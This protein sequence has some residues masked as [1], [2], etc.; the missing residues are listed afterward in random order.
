MFLFICRDRELQITDIEEERHRLREKEHGKN[1]LLEAYLNGLHEADDKEIT[2]GNSDSGVHTEETTTSPEIGATSSG[3]MDENSD[4]YPTTSRKKSRSKREAEL[5]IEHE[6]IRDSI[7]NK[8]KDPEIVPSATNNDDELSTQIELLERLVVLNKHLQK[9]EELLVRLGAKIKRY[10]ADASGLTEQQVKEAIEKVDTQLNQGTSELQH[11]ECQIKY[12]DEMLQDKSNALKNLYDE[13]E[14]AEIEHGRLSQE[15][16][17]QEAVSRD[18]AVIP[19]ANVNQCR[20]YLADNVYNVSKSILKTKSCYDTLQNREIS[21]YI[22]HT[23]EHMLLNP[24]ISVG[25]SYYHNTNPGTSSALPISI[26]HI[27][28][29]QPPLQFS[30]QQTQAQI[31]YSPDLTSRISNTKNANTITSVDLL[32]S[33][34]YL[35]K[36]NQRNNINNNNVMQATNIKLG[37]KKISLQEMLFAGGGDSNSSDTGLSSLSCEDSITNLGTL[38]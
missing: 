37:P 38:V 19:D 26:H 22:R 24:N 9:E 12:S 20:E 28:V 29:L 36:Y 25:P 23:P 11:M 17:L 35:D 33:M 32:S 1:Y 15:K 8:E 21:D 34:N 4:T 27:P 7:S 30:Q 16:L 3:H 18:I 2:T 5:L 13:L 6:S 10:E 31:H 14:E